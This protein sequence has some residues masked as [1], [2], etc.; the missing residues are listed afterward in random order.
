MNT[1]YFQKQFTVF[2]SYD[3]RTWCIHYRKKTIPIF[4]W[5]TR[6]VKSYNAIFS[7]FCL[8]NISFY[9]LKATIECIVY[10]D[11]TP[12]STR[13]FLE[14]IYSFWVMFIY[15]SMLLKNDT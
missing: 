8:Q 7:A 5:L 3:L 1:V 2:L 4:D 13:T 6:R 11:I 9:I 12:K 14:F 10:V 15:A